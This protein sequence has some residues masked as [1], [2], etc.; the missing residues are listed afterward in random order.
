MCGCG[1]CHDVV[2]YVALAALLLFASAC[3]AQVTLN[4]QTGLALDA[5]DAFASGECLCYSDADNLA[6][7]AIPAATGL[8]CASAC[9]DIST[10]TNLTAGAGIALV[11]DDLRT[12]SLE[13]NFLAGSDLGCGASSAG[14][15]GYM[16]AGYL[17]WCD[18]SGVANYAAAGNSDAEAL[19]GD[20][21]T[22][23]F[24]A[25]TLETA[26]G[27]TGTSTTFT[28]GSVVFAG[29][30][31]VYSQDNAGLFYDRVNGVLSLG[32][33]TPWDAAN[34]N[35]LQVICDGET[36]NPLFAG[37]GASKYPIVIFAHAEGTRASPTATIDNAALG[38]LAWGGWEDA[39]TL[40]PGAGIA[41]HATE[42]WGTNAHGAELRFSTCA[43]S[44]AGGCTNR[45]T[46]GQDGAL[47]F[48]S[49]SSVT[50]ASATAMILRQAADC[51]GAT[52]EGS[53]C[54]DTDDDRLCC[55][56][57]ATCRVVWGKR[58]V[59][60]SVPLRG[61]GTCAVTEAAVNSGEV[62]P[63]ATCTDAAT[64]VLGYSILMPEA[65]DAGTVKIR[66]VAQSVNATPSGTAALD[67]SCEC[68][69]ND[70][71][72]DA[73]STAAVVALDFAFAAQY[74]VEIIKTASLTCADSCAAGDVL[75]LRCVVD[76]TTTDATMADVR[77]L[78]DV[79]L[80]YETTGDEE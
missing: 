71:T 31:G 64:S 59:P 18:G 42:N 39:S 5:T 28:D 68:D 77:I 70:D 56:T 6:V 41:A 46:L 34:Y 80:L 54:W 36:C 21:A 25:G 13:E 74:D 12:A 57:G 16:S 40:M 3:L 10:E 76:A 79:N 53:C 37:F 22:A 38:Q 43:D 52:A 23:F 26:R 49:S 50:M 47:T 4:N 24:D 69:S 27:G 75:S 61:S 62:L 66:A 60:V 78:A 33:A 72:H 14:M 19:V 7:V 2:R 51:S 55:G 20:S 63:W 48:S 8:V 15:L 29:A 9:V 35:D 58:T 17:N 1:G 32:S 73:T 65:W 30:S 44:T 11:D 45:I 67:C